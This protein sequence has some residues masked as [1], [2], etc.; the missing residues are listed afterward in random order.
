MCGP[1]VVVQ[2]QNCTSRFDQVAG[3]DAQSRQLGHSLV[4]PFYDENRPIGHRQSPAAYRGGEEVV[5]LGSR[6]LHPRRFNA[7]PSAKSVVRTFLTST[8]TNSVS[9]RCHIEE[10]DRLR[11]SFFPHYLW[12]L[13][14][15]DLLREAE[16]FESPDSIPVHVDFV[17]LQAVTGR[18]G[19]GMMIVVPSFPEGQ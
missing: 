13:D 1:V 8:G 18:S 12:Q 10:D 7:A 9:R 17:P 15:F 4:C 6:D 2:V 16:H 3:P 5:L 14:G 11:R 19:M